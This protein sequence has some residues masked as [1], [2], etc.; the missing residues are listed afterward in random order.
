MREGEGGGESFYDCLQRRRVCYV[1]LTL[2]FFVKLHC[3][4]NIT[5]TL[6]RGS[7]HL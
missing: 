6:L 1:Y 2:S 7:A 5:A 3:C 4:I